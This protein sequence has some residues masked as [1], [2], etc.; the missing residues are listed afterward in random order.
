VRRDVVAWVFHSP[1]RLAT[2]VGLPLVAALALGSWWVNGQSR[3]P[4]EQVTAATAGPAATSGPVV[5]RLPDAAPFVAVAVDFADRWAD[6]APGQTR[7]GW[8]RDVSSRATPELAAG[9]ALTDPAVLPGGHPEG[10]PE[11]RYVADDSALVAVPLSAGDTVVVTVV[12]MGG[13]LLVADVQ[14][15][16]GDAGDVP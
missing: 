10:P 8:V 14:P 12:Q 13:T 15:D 7:Q 9:L 4:S 3:P 2:V 16:L 11:V 5:A 6:L 1:A